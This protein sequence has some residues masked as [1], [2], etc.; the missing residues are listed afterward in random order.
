MFKLERRIKKIEWKR[1]KKVLTIIIPN[2]LNVYFYMIEMKWWPHAKKCWIEKRKK[3]E[4][5]NEIVIKPT[6]KKK[7]KKEEEE[8]IAL[9]S[10]NNMTNND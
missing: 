4:K 7:T 8:E 6:T 2:L 10:S 3:I 9:N 5:M 1:K